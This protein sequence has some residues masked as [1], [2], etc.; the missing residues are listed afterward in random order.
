M[1]ALAPAFVFSSIPARNAWVIFMPC[2]PAFRLC[3]DR[4]P[5]MP[6]RLPALATFTVLLL[7]PVEKLVSIFPSKPYFF[8]GS[9]CMAMFIL[10]TLS[11]L[12]SSVVT[13]ATF[14]HTPVRE[15]FD[16]VLLYFSWLYKSPFLKPSCLSKNFLFTIRAVSWYSNKDEF[17]RVSF[18]RPISLFRCASSEL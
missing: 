7:L 3:N 9:N 4:L 15:K 13:M 18:I 5:E 10:P 6:S 11:P 12:F 17:S 2:L 1:S 16:S 8:A 14:C